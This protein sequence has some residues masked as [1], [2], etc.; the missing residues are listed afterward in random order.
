MDRFDQPAAD[1]AF[2]RNRHFDAKRGA[3]FLVW[4][5]DSL[6]IASSGTGSV[7]QQSQQDMR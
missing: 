6:D 7:A 5:G 1:S 4:N 3:D 2:G